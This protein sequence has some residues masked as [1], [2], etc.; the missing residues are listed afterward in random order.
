MLIPFS[1]EV[2]SLGVTLDSKLTWK[3][4]IN[5]LTK[6]L[7]KV[8]YSL[9]FI[10]ACTSETLRKRL[11]ETL[12][13]PHLD[14]FSVVYFDVTNEQ[15]L[16]LERLSN[17]CVRYILGVRRDAHIIPHRRRLGWLHPDSRK[18]YFAALLLYKITRM[19]EPSY[20][21][22]FCEA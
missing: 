9:R 18:L 2:V 8:P 16:R 22:A 7:N 4:H 1:S 21:A 3:P 19:R 13:Q 11:V 6:K 5:Q 17:S 12:V 10:R 15:K 20:L 14:Y